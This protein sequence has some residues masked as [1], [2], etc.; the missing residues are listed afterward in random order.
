VGSTP[1]QIGYSYVF[2]EASILAER[3]L[4]VHVIRPKLHKS[5]QSH[6]ITFHGFE[7]KINFKSFKLMK[8]VL[9]YHAPGN[10]ILNKKDLYGK[11]LYATE[12]SKFVKKYDIDLIHAHLTYPEGFIGLITKAITK[13]PL[14]VTVHGFD[15]LKEGKIG[16]GIRLNKNKDRIIKKI[17]K[18]SDA[19]IVASHA[20]YKEVQKIIH[21]AKRIHLIPNGVDIGKFNPSLD[22]N[23]VRKKFGVKET[24]LVFSL[25]H[26]R[27]VYGLKY[28]IKAAAIV[29]EEYDDVFFIIGGKG[30]LLHYHKKIANKLEISNKIIFTGEIK[31]MEVPHYY[32]AS[33]VVVVPSLQEAFGLVVSE[34]M[35]TGK[36]VIGTDVGGIPDQIIDGYNGFLVKKKKSNEIADKILWILENED[37]AITMGFNGRKIAENKFNL[38]KRVT[39]IIDLYENLLKEK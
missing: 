33:D 18:T 39:K 26:H 4:D 20:T 36:P 14:I 27:Q 10:I 7:K 35:A 29:L 2:D 1:E 16:Y 23:I 37:K 22:R 31:R 38:E 32:A 28:L 21:N 17:L 19:I 6:K 9:H 12:A 3:G 24:F 30:E 5:F 25:R 8:N 15:I 13:K 34:A 11:A